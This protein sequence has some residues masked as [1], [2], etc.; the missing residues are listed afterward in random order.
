[1]NRSICLAIASAVI[2]GSPV[3]MTFAQ[4]DQGKH[5][6]HHKFAEWLDALSADQLA[7]LRAARTKALNNPD[8]HAADERRKKADAEFHNLL[9]QEMLRIDPSLKT[10]LDKLEELRKYRDTEL[11]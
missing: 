7:K 6:K 9:R 4:D 1:M 11:P 8:V 10:M 3:V 2:A 5:G